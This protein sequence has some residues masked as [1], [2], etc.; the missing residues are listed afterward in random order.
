MREPDWQHDGSMDQ[1]RRSALIKALTHCDQNIA[2]TAERL[3]IGRS[4]LYRLL[5]EFDIKVVRDSSKDVCD[6]PAAAKPALQQR[7]VAKVQ[8][9]R[10]GRLVQIDGEFFMVC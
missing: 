1:A 5:K 6:R 4:S 2:R 10:Q 8:T 7:E 3:R 9:P